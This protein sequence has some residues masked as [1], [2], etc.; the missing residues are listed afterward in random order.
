MILTSNIVHLAG[1]D[2]AMRAAD[3]LIISTPADLSQ[4]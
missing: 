2:Q 1:N 4:L 3:H